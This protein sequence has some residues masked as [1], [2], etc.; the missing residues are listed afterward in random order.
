M[1][2]T[3]QTRLADKWDAALELQLRRQH[4]DN[5]NMF[6]MPLMYSV[7]PWIYYRMN[8]HFSLS[9]SPLAWFR[10]YP[11]LLTEKDLSKAP[12][13]EWRSTVAISYQTQLQQHLYFQ[14]RAGV[15]YRNFST[16]QR[17]L[18]TRIRTG[19]Q[20]LLPGD[21]SLNAYNELMLN[22]AG[23]APGHFFDQNRQSISGIVPLSRGVTV[24]VGYMHIY[25]QLPTYD[26][27]M[28]EHNYF[29]QLNI[30]MQ[31]KK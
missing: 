19:F 27:I 29:V 17:L 8:T 26:P 16:G 11:V 22:P 9:V 13:Q 30:S 4:P 7:R 14:S 15:E 31:R 6:S 23:A 2:T 5:A 24:E 1:R 18:R 12:M 28:Q 25:R 20:Y 3:L 21:V 10:Q